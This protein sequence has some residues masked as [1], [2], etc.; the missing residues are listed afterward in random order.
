[1]KITSALLVSML[2]S[3]CCKT[4]AVQDNPFLQLAGKRYAEYSQELFTEYKSHLSSDTTECRKIILQ[5][6]EVA[7]KTGSIEWT[8]LSE[9]L[10]I[11]LFEAKMEIF[12]AELFPFE[13][14]YEMIMD[15]LD[16]TQKAKTLPIELLVRWQ[17]IE[18]RFNK[19]KKYELAF[20]EC[21]IQDRI[22]R[23]VTSEDIPEKEQFYLQ[24]ANNYY[25]FKDYPTAIVYFKKILEEKETVYNQTPKQSARN[26]LGLSYLYTNHL[27]SAEQYFQAIKQV[28]YLN[29]KNEFYHDIFDA[30]AEGNIGAIMLLRGENNQAL[31]LFESSLTKALNFDDNPFAASRAVDLADIYLKKDN[32][33]EAKRYIDL[34]ISLRNKT[35][36]PRNN[37]LFYKVLSNYYAATGDANQSIVY[38]DLMLEEITRNKEEF[39][40]ILLLRMTQ[41]ESL[42]RQS[43]LEQEK[44]KRRQLQIRLMLI[45]VGFIGITGLLGW[46][47]VLYRKRSAAY[48]AL[49]RKSQEWAQTTHEFIKETAGNSREKETLQPISEIDRQLFEQMQQMVQKEHLYRNTMLSVEEIAHRLK[50]N[51]TYL[52]RAINHCTGNNFNVYINEYRI[53]E[54]VR[55]MSD[56]SEKFSL[57][58]FAYEVGF[59]DRKTF[60][61]AFKKFTGLSPSVFR[62]NLLKKHA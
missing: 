60:Y 19:V 5:V 47:F 43:E 56:D 30:I 23:T 40:A 20:H 2:L 61:V 25:F 26:G 49:V 11:L 6:R 48:R 34:A 14:F 21:T 16:K 27:D 50:V 7:R 31:L 51:R 46:V 15:L 35:K 1:M 10:E 54:A 55:L 4:L 37:D 17:L 22:L 53:K 3:L 41:T 13:V 9:Y 8:L 59:N 62:S 28:I 33:S 12:G 29:A 36:T 18:F 24:I 52:S 57:E 58:G 32:L 45:S 42:M 39:N 44:E 38:M